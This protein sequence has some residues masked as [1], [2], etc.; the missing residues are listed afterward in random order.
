MGRG[1]RQGGPGHPV[2][3]ASGGE[4]LERQGSAGFDLSNCGRPDQGE[5]AG[6]DTEVLQHRERFHQGGGRSDSE[7][8]PVGV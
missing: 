7:G 1:I 4:L 5:D 3:S 8:E 2:R 6:G